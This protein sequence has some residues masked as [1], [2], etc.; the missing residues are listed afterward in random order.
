MGVREPA[1]R[2]GAARAR[3]AS[4]GAASIQGRLTR[5]WLSSSSSWLL[6]ACALFLVAGLYVSVRSRWR[7]FIPRGQHETAVHA[8]GSLL[9]CTSVLI[10]ARHTYPS[11]AHMSHETHVSCQNLQAT[12]I[13]TA[14]T[15]PAELFSTAITASPGQPARRAGPRSEGTPLPRPLASHGRAWRLDA[16]DAPSLRRRAERS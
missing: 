15:H 13:S 9:S 3:G 10:S 1:R 14:D 5:R 11:H 16:R 2:R 7:E 12:R 4:R 8:T 6:R